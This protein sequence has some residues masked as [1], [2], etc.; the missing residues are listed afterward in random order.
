[1]G[2]TGDIF[3]KIRDT[4]GIFHENIGMEEMVWT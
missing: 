4:E 3:K 1:M 2:K